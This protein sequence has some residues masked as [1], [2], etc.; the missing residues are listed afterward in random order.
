MLDEVGLE[1]TLDWYIPTVE[2]QTGITISYEKQGNP[3]A[4][5]GAAGVH[6]YRVL[7]EAVNN[8]ARHSG[9]KQA[10]VR[11]RFSR[12]ALELE[13]EDHGV[14]LAERR[15]GRGIGLVAMRER[16]E[17]MGGE[18]QFSRPAEGGTLLHLIVPREKAEA[19]TQAER[20]EEDHDKEDHSIAGG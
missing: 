16:S 4:L 20:S 17:L 7:Q 14:G 19:R 5:D 2:R 18:I 8:V 1:S 3:F 10:W 9:A 6:I 15:S 13:V 11:L 12:L